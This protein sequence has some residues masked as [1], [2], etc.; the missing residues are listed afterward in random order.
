[1]H[2]LLK[3]LNTWQKN[4]FKLLDERL[5]FTELLF[6]PRNGCLGLQWGLKSSDLDSVT[7]AYVWLGI[8]NLTF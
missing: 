7:L 8:N 6:S 1:M 2:F 4:V 3:K 5:A